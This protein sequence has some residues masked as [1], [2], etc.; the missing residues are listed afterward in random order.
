VG[1]AVFLVVFGYRGL[2]PEMQR[3]RML[4]ARFFLGLRFDPEDGG[5]MFI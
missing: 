5:N 1:S 2:A 3:L 4:H